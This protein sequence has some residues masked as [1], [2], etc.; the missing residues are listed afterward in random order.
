MKRYQIQLEETT[1]KDVR[2]AAQNRGVSFAQ[3]V[4]EAVEQYVAKPDPPVLA[5]V[6]A[7]I[8]GMG[9]DTEGRADV[10]ARHDEFAWDH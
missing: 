5:E 10:A 2:A 9:R 1:A 7:P 4:R 6:W 3:V 8:I